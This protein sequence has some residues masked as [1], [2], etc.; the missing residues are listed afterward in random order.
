MAF[1]NHT[2]QE[3]THSSTN[4]LCIKKT[5]LDHA[6]KIIDSILKKA[7]STVEVPKVSWEDIG[8]LEE[9]KKELINSVRLPLEYPQLFAA[10]IRRS[11]KFD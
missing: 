9:V 7:A 10:G 3:H 8:G 2:E 11:G 4:K 5:D 6:V 1:I